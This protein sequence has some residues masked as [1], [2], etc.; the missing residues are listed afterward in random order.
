MGERDYLSSID[1][2]ITSSLDDLFGIDEDVKPT[3]E[4]YV[5]LT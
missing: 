2:N 3:H 5:K 1:T 4:P